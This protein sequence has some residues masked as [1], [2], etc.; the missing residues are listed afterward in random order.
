MKYIVEVHIFCTKDYCFSDES[1]FCCYYCYFLF[2]LPL[3]VLLEILSL[4]GM[5]TLF[6]I[7]N[8]TM[9]CD[10]SSLRLLKAFKSLQISLFP[11]FFN[12]IFKNTKNYFKSLA[13]TVDNPGKNGPH[14]VCLY[15]MK[16]SDMA[17]R[18]LKSLENLKI[19][20]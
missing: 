20:T 18:S 12:P 9:K 8:F 4:S 2:V 6:K 10:F 3:L 17:K 11:S 14:F 15:C 16:L 7:V 19:L 1:K 5:I 13:L